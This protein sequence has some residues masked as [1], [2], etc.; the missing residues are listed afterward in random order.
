M[1]LS[2]DEI[3]EDR[4][5]VRKITKID[6]MAVTP[7]LMFIAPLLIIYSNIPGKTE[8]RVNPRDIEFGNMPTTS[9]VKLYCRDICGL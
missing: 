5:P 6:S 4:E 8:A 7:S 9:F 1:V 3:R 2:A